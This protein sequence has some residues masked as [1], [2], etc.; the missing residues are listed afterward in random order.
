MSLDNWILFSGFLFLIFYKFSKKGTIYRKVF[1]ILA[2]L[3]FLGPSLLPRQLFGRWNLIKTFKE[4]EVRSILLRPSLPDWQVNLTDSLV[5][6]SDKRQIADITNLLKK[7]NAYFPNHPIRIWESDL[8]LISKDND[9][10]WLHIDKT[11]NNGTIITSSSN[12][13]YRKDELADYLEK[14][15]DFKK[16]SFMKK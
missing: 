7:V 16:P 5:V 9:S 2:V 15:T 13:Y 1:M 14:V 11:E 12:S 10:V 8:I 4:K 6:I 3:A